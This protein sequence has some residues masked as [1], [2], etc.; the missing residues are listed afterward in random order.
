MTWQPIETAPK[1]RL[2][3]LW[4]PGAQEWA[5]CD[6][7][8]WDEDRYARRPRP[9]WRS[10]LNIRSILRMRSWYPTHWQPL[11]TPPSHPTTDS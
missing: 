11:P 5:K 6:I 2:I 4:R 9:Y 8:K 7:G 3:L 1:D 10:F